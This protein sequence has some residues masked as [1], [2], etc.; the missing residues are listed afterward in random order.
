MSAT[1]NK[2][3]FLENSFEEADNVIET[4]VDGE[5]YYNNKTRGIVIGSDFQLIKIHQSSP[6]FLQED[7]PQSNS[8]L[9]QKLM[10]STS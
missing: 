2:I 3:D 8:I 10:R 4:Y 5:Q 9:P 7:L 6:E 1:R